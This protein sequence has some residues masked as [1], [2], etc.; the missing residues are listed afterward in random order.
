M[1]EINGITV[2]NGTKGKRIDYKT[3]VDTLEELEDLRKQIIDG[4]SGKYEISFETRKPPHV[5]GYWA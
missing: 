2:L 5:K 4:F 1:V 3:T